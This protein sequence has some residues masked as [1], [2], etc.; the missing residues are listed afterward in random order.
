VPA[1][2]TELKKIKS[3][4]T[5]KGRTRH[6]MFLAEGVRLLEESI[7]HRFLP[8]T[9]YYAHAMLSSRGKK[10]IKLFEKK[11]LQTISL[12]AKELRSISDTE[13]PQGMVGLFATPS[14]KLSELCRPPFRMLLLCEN[15]SEPGN[16]GALTRSAL[17][18]GFDPVLLSRNSAEPYSPKAVRASAGAVFGLRIM[19]VTLK[20]IDALVLEERLIVIAADPGSKTL[21][22]LPIKRVKG[23]KILLAIGSEAGG[24]SKPLL[25]R[26]D[27]RVRIWHS[28]AVESLN[29]AVAGSILMKEMYQITH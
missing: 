3:L 12:T 18:F 19:E 25:A 17:A 11:G 7:R 29:A 26:S 24:L 16:L 23:K 2:R 28:D 1:T 27:F 13:T 6:Q 4:L 5:K 21:A 20:E 22:K 8:L 15:I 10:L 14:R 9:V